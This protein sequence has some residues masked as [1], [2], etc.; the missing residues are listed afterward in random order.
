MVHHCAAGCGVVVCRPGGICRKDFR[1]WQ[2]VRKL[3]WGRWGRAATPEE[4]RDEIRWRS[5]R[6]AA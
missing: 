2:N 3:L 4:I 1:L 5:A 6:K